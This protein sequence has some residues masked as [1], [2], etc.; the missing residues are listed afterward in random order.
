MLS[1]IFTMLLGL[2]PQSEKVDGLL[3]KIQAS[4]DRDELLELL[5]SAIPLIG[6]ADDTHVFKLFVEKVSAINDDEEERR[7]RIWTFSL[8]FS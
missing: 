6:E 5:C 1:D 7:G 2:V 3:R 8:Y 4:S